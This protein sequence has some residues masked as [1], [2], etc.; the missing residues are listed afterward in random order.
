MKTQTLPTRRSIVVGAL[1]LPATFSIG[2]MAGCQGNSSLD[3]QLVFSS[4]AAAEQ[5]LQ[6]LAAAKGLTSGTVWNWD[7]TLAHC[8]QSI[9]FSMQG[10]PEPKSKLFQSTV[11][12]AAFGVFAWRG[13]M[14]HDLA[15]PIPGAPLL[16]AGDEGVVAL[17]RLQNAI[18]GFQQWTKPL[19]P[20]FA[21]GDLDKAQYELAHAMH[22]ANHFSQFNVIS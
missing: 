3:R 2:G 22:L 12:S 21:Y 8:A 18:A 9:E 15:E 6:R 1:A 5:E 7:Q 19:Q 4:L 13:R 17:E 11:G 10:F 16:A 14:T 20:H